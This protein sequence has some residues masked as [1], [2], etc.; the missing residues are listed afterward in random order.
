[1]IDGTASAIKY[2][3]FSSNFCRYAQPLVNDAGQSASV[4]VA[5]AAMG[6]NPPYINAGN[7]SK[8]PPPAIAF[9]NPAMNPAP[10][11]NGR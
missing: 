6:D 1:M 7:D 4:L 2:R 8:V 5:L 10:Q 9:T 3:R 11:I